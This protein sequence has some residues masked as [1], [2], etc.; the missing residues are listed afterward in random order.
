MCTSANAS[1][2]CSRYLLHVFLEAGCLEWCV[3][4]GL[5]L[6]DSS[7]IKQVV[8]FLDCPDVP[9]ET[10]LSI[11]SGLL[12]VDAWASSDWSAFT[13]LDIFSVLLTHTD[14][15]FKAVTCKHT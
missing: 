15:K 3:I 6:R 2:D 11:R 12:A 7:I 14:I 9:Q 8:S 13:H 10:V 5:I 1:D 4:I